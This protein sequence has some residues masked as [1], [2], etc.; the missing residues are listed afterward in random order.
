[1]KKGFSFI[2]ILMFYSGIVFPQNNTAVLYGKITNKKGIPLELVNIIILTEK[3]GTTTNEKGFYKLKVPAATKITVQYSMLGYKT[4]KKQFL[5]KPGEIK[6]IAIVLESTANTLNEVSI[7]DIQQRNNNLV[8][9]NPRLIQTVP[10]PNIGI[11][12]IIKTLPG[13][14]SNNE[15]SSQYSVRGG[16]YDENLVYVNDIEVYRPFLVRSGQQ[17]AIVA[18]ASQTAIVLS[19][20]WDENNGNIAA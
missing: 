4:I 10:S 13:V 16:N 20:H 2:L 5:L 1:M 3:T 17:E 6:E 9:I 14:H 18:A 15:L 12:S 11:A 7:S 19:M 8:R